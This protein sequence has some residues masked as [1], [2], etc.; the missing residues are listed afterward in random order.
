VDMS[1]DQI[2]SLLKD[3]EQRMKAAADAVSGLEALENHNLSSELALQTRFSSSS[4]QNLAQSYIKASDKG[5]Q[6]DP[7]LLVTSKERSLS[8]GARV[9]QSQASIK[10]A[11]SKREKANAGSD[12]YNLPRTNLSEEFK[13]DLQLLRLRGV[14]DPHRHYKKGGRI[15][16]SQVPEFSEVGTIVEG[17]TEFFSSRLT[18]KERK[19]T[20]VEEVL[21][22]EK[23]NGHFRAKYNE[24]QSAK[25]SGKKVHYKTVK[26]MR[27]R[28]SFKG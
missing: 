28:K 13:R 18:N 9:V 12:W 20:F 8:N 14:L 1:D 15:G 21:A 25:T 5:A 27:S 22:A 10:A 17:P 7:A 19:Q 23:T 3:A 2:F 6:I 24:I 4:N 26:A 11:A 16:T